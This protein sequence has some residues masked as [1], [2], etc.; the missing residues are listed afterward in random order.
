MKKM[1]TVMVVAMM[2]ASGLAF[3]V[4][5]LSS[6]K[7]QD[8]TTLGSDIEGRA[9]DGTS[10]ERAS[11]S[12]QRPTYAP[13][14]LFPAT[15]QV[16][17]DSK[18]SEV[19]PSSTPGD[20]LTF[21]TKQVSYN[22]PE[23][24]EICMVSGNNGN[25][26][27]YYMGWNDYR[28]VNWSKGYVH[29]GFSSSEDGGKI[30]SDNQILGNRSEG[31]MHDCAGDPLI[32]PGSGDDLY[33]VMM[34][35]NESEAYQ[36]SLDHSQ[37]VIKKST[38][39]G[40]TWTDE[41]LI[42]GYDV[43]KPWGKFYNG[44][45]YVAWDNVSEY[46][47]EFSHTVGG[48]MHSWTQKIEIPGY[49]LYPYV[50]IN[51]TGAIYVATVHWSGSDWEQMTVSV[52]TD[53]GDSFGTQNVIGSVGGHSWESTPRS[54]PIPAMAVN[55]SDIYV[56]WA[57]DDTYSQVYLAESHDGANTWT[58][59][60]VA[61]IYG[62]D[63]RYMYPSVTIGANGT[64]GLEYYRMDTN[65]KDISVIYRNYTN[66]SFGDEILVDSWT[67]SNKF[68]GDYSS[69]ITAKNG[70]V[71]I[72]YTAENPTDN[73]MFAAPAP[74][75]S[76]DIPVHTGW[77]LISFPLLV[78]NGNIETVLKDD[79]TWDY[80][81][82]YNP[83]DTNDHWKTHF[84]GRASNDLNTID[85]TMGI[86]LRITDAGDGSLTVNGSIPFTTVIQLHAGWNLVSYPASDLT[87]MSR[88]NLPS[89]VTKIAK[90]D[91]TAPYLISEVTDWV[92]SNFVPGRGY[93]LYAT[94]DT[95]W[96]V[97]Y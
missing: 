65:N 7:N 95:T 64:V 68:I 57:S 31:D 6:N 61:E 34:E 74:S 69:I 5:S 50:A 63:Y 43:D 52:S 94:A 56:V 87:A 73:A 88:A 58:N 24:N 9:P 14:T 35:F 41:A 3:A 27:V 48:N 38:D 28:E 67:N 79:I 89:E 46:Q 55:G 97:N 49:N 40:Q 72:G 39:R 60:S 26:S 2:I 45:V 82:C 25:N 19:S 17:S 80:A 81:Q 44:D 29:L 51:K 92:G 4:H 71:S 47:S 33:Y 54:G 10:T 21:R 85:D 22:S 91:S 37:L 30:W 13:A 42:W 36:Q 12:V 16:A 70:N 15:P 86:W 75:G 53:G 66:G 84:V 62:S 23:A 8:E 90:Y 76:F 11:K 18:S 78:P 96:N 77:N 93:W 83:L 59:R 20:N 1:L 32:I